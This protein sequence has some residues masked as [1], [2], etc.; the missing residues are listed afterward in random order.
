MPTAARPAWL[1]DEASVKQLPAADR[2]ELTDLIHRPARGEALVSQPEA[3]LIAP[4]RVD[5]LLAV[6]EHLRATFAT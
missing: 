1:A 3:R 5:A 4:A 2:D 6:R